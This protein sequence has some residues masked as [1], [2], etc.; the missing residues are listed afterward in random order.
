MKWEE[1]LEAQMPQNKLAQAGMMCV[2]CDL[3]PCVINPFDEQPQVGACGIDA[4]GMNYVNLGMT[5]VKGLSDYQ[6]TDSL[7]L[8]LDRMVGPHH[9]AGISVQNILGASSKIL[10]GSKNLV[11]SW[12][13]EQRKLREIEH[14]IGVLERDSVNIV[15]TVYEPE[16]VKQSRSQAMRNLAREN[17]ALGINLVG[18]LCGGAE[19]SYNFGIPLLGCAEE[20]EEAQDMIDYVYEGGD[21]A[22]ACKKAV[23]NFSKR[24]RAAFRHFTP[25]RFTVGH[26]ID[27]EK[28]N[29][30]VDR[31]ILKGVVA[32]FGCESGKSTWKVDEL[33]EELY[34]HDFMVINLGCHLRGEQG[35]ST[36]SAEY[37]IPSV[38]NAGCCEP[39]K[40]LGLK[41][42]TVLMPRWRDPRMLTQAFAFASCKIP[43][44][45]GVLPFVIPRV[46]SEL[47]DAGIK[48]E[49]DSSKILELLG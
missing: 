15:E 23:E 24:D 2:Y 12:G 22:E 16:L 11:E 28:I 21:A 37:G 29:E 49:V 31:G 26:D 4:A 6:A 38:L 30:A 7:S 45:L 5:V 39:G 43:V 10:G 32:L 8:S 35:K 48:V 18:A 14:G 13:S 20:I 46:R 44:I 1:R 41:K 47:M 19:V 33:I 40:V 34:Q 3:G 17:N 9:T 27:E 36:F 42:L 25:K